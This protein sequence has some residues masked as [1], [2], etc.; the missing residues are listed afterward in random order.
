MK[1]FLMSFRFNKQSP[2]DFGLIYQNGKFYNE[3][4][5][6]EWKQCVLFDLGWGEENGYYKVPLASFEK[7]MQLVLSDD[8]IEDSYGAAAMIQKVYPTALKMY[9]QTLICQ[10]VHFQDRKKLKKLNQFFRLQRG[11]NLTYIA[12]MTKDEAEKE[13]AA[14]QEI[15]AFFS[16]H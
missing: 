3:K 8:D 7:L 10:K 12:G 11:L 2:Q 14:W 1:H 15:A 4:D 5:G 13:N 6:A 16:S 9:L